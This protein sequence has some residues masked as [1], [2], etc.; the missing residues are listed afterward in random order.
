[1]TVVT[2]ASLKGAAGSG[3]GQVNC[4]HVGDTQRY[5]ISKSR[6]SGVG[7]YALAWKVVQGIF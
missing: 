5:S 1:M 6:K 2:A 4:V 7:L 3:Y